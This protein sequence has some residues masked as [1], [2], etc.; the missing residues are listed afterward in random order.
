MS[1]SLGDIHEKCCNHR[2]LIINSVNCGC[3]FC[4]EI[5]SPNKIEEWIDENELGIGQTA[6]CP[7][8]G[9]DSVIGSYIGCDINDELLDK[10]Y[11]EYFRV[12]N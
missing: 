11:S 12:D 4:K 5:F 8:C 3:F 9:V 7:Y 1:M 10:M 2:E 6:L